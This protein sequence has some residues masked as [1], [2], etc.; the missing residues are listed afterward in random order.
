MILFTLI[1]ILSSAL[2]AVQGNLPPTC[3][4]YPDTNPPKCY[5]MVALCFREDFPVGETMFFLIGEDPDDNPITF[6]ITTGSDF[7]DVSDQNG[8]HAQVKLIQELDYETATSH[9][10]IFTLSD[11]FNDIVAEHVTL[12]VIDVNDNAP[13]FIGTPY[14]TEVPEDETIG[15][16]VQT[17]S[18]TD[19]DSG[20]N[21]QFDFHLDETS[22]PEGL[23]ILETDPLDYEKAYLIL[24]SPLD[25]ETENG[26]KPVVVATDRGTDPMQHSSSATVTVAV[27]DVQDTPPRFTFHPYSANLE[28]NKPVGSIVLEVEAFDGD[29]ANRQDI[30]FMIP[31]STDFWVETVQSFYS[32]GII[33]TSVVFDRETMT[34]D[35]FPIVFTVVAKEID[36][37]NQTL[38]A[39]TS[40]TTVAVMI[41]DVNDMPPVF[42]KE[43]YFGDVMEQ[44]P[45]HSVVGNI[46]IQIDDPDEFD[47]GRFRIQILE[48]G[49]IADQAFYL[50]P[51]TALNKAY[52]VIRVRNELLLDYS[53]HQSFHFKILAEE[54]STDEKF[55]STADV[56]V[57]VDKVERPSQDPR[58]VSGNS[59]VNPSVCFEVF[60]FMC[61][62]LLWDFVG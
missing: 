50:S 30:E 49:G 33:R 27:L 14:S 38:N 35:E 25:F 6:G 31:D 43:H 47:N 5:N 2:V 42:E 44:S 29:T 55:K 4:I 37:Y 32:K 23:F 3:T 12:Y 40:S 20:Q 28:E 56:T 52:V 57:N 24:N 13:E 11:G 15:T 34:E 19:A 9:D 46:E 7:F 22:F 8:T 17:V 45:Q 60:V 41:D 59:R 48:E 18:A 16:T 1:I 39:T 36:F 62:A 51:E 58:C 61:L 54:T 53:K 21:G 26:Y 10:I